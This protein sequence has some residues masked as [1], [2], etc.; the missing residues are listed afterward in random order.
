MALAETREW[1]CFCGP[2]KWGYVCFGWYSK[3][4]DQSPRQPRDNTSRAGAS[5]PA[6]VE[7]AAAGVSPEVLVLAP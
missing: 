5:T 4:W 1:A 6:A 7:P 2:A 3:L